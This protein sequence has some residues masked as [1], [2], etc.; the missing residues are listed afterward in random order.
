MSEDNEF[1]GYSDDDNYT[2]TNI[3]DSYLS[4]DPYTPIAEKDFVNETIAIRTK[5]IEV[6]R[7]D[8]KAQINLN[9]NIGI[10]I[11][12]DT[13]GGMQSVFLVDV[14]GNIIANN[15]IL[16]GG[17]IST[18]EDVISKQNTSPSSPTMNQI[19]VD[20]SV[21]PSVWK[22][23]NGSAWIK[24]TRSDLG[25]L[26]GAISPSQITTETIT[27]VGVDASA[28]ITDSLSAISANI[29]TVTAGRLQNA[30]NTSFLDLTTGT[31]TLGTDMFVWNGTSLSMKG[32]ITNTSFDGT[33]T[34]TSTMN[35]G[36]FTQLWQ[37][38]SIR[39]TANL[40]G[41]IGINNTTENW[42]GSAWVKSKFSNFTASALQTNDTTSATNQYMGSV[43]FEHDPN[44]VHSI[45]ATRQKAQ[46]R[47]TNVTLKADKLAGNVNSVLDGWLFGGGLTLETNSGNL[48]GSN[49]ASG[50]YGIHM[51]N[52][53]IRGINALVFQDTADAINEGILFPRQLVNDSND[54]TDYDTFRMI[55]GKIYIDI[56]GVE[57]TAPFYDNGAINSIGLF[58]KRGYFEIYSFSPGTYGSANKIQ[59]WF[60][61]NLVTW[62]I[63]A[64]KISD[65][66]SV[67]IIVD[68]NGVVKA[69][70]ATLTSN[71]AAKKN[72]RPYDEDAIAEVMSTPVSF[73]QFNEELDGELPHV[74]MI[75]D[76]V[77]AYGASIDGSGV[78]SYAL[79]SIL[80]RA[81]QQQQDKII[82]LE[83]KLNAKTS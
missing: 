6:I 7:N 54:I 34:T 37:N 77:P 50:Y 9:A 33:R 47:F 49:F 48:P 62:N 82:E 14:N 10:E 21:N 59:T 23:W 70:G 53:D 3:G 71:R 45:I 83:M 57:D 58:N 19:W 68:V 32:N 28:I 51:K 25:D 5:D 26:T 40:D 81:F 30:S 31:F 16:N 72:I 52:N 74:G 11:L 61:S 73:Y 44:R 66:T 4:R 46:W 12:A 55:N 56:A 42:N 1:V 13:G 18:K 22:Q 80:W 27:A 65:S 15:L 69:K 75:A 76:E 79:L 20:T 63:G 41:E 38:A 2:V 64:R 17:T 35:N 8:G 78:D 67:D 36:V 29:G 24:M 39:Y 60:N 43:L